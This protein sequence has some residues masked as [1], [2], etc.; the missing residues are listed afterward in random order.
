MLGAVALVY[1]AMTSIPS[2]L[3]FAGGLC[4]GYAVAI[5]LVERILRAWRGRGG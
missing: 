4:L 5:Y 2:A 1:P 3:W